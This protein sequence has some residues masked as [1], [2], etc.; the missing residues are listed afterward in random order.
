MDV[1]QQA[2]RLVKDSTFEQFHLFSELPPELRLAIWYMALSPRVITVAEVPAN[3]AREEINLKTTTSA[4]DTPLLQV[5]RESRQVALETLR[6]SS[7]YFPTSMSRIPTMSISIIQR[8]L[9]MSN[10]VSAS[11]L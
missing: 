5:N 11:K 3:H 1:D 9:S 7:P 4:R 2:V 6:L 10:N 8:T